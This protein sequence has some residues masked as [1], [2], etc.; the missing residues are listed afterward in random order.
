MS[1]G[2]DLIE[3]KVTKALENEFSEAERQEFKL[4]TKA[5]EAK[6][7]EW[8]KKNVNIVEKNIKESRGISFSL[9]VDEIIPPLE[10]AW[11]KFSNLIVPVLDFRF[12]SAGW[13]SFH[14]T[15]YTRDYKAGSDWQISLS[16]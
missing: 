11:G 10:L 13:H 4:I 7:D 15:F 16:H 9:K 6:I 14:A 12:R 1:F 5:L 3:A 8:I 2:P